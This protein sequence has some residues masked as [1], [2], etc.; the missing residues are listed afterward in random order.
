[1][2]LSVGVYRV[3]PVSVR[4]Y[5]SRGRGMIRFFSPIGEG[6]LASRS[7]AIPTRAL[8]GSVAKE[9]CKS[10]GEHLDRRIDRCR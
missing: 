8:N 4:N 6:P 10:L 7:F 5:A 1:L 9:G 2:N 3:F